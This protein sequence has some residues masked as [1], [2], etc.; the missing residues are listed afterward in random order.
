MSNIFF[1]PSAALSAVNGGDAMAVA[2]DFVLVILP[3][4]WPIVAR[5]DF[6]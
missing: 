1:R 6:L 3:V 4:L 5:I 2:N